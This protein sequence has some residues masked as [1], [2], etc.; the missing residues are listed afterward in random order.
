MTFIND[1]DLIIKKTKFNRS[2]VNGSNGNSTNDDV[3]Y[4]KINMTLFNKTVYS[5]DQDNLNIHRNRVED[6]DL[7]FDIDKINLIQ[8]SE[9]NKTAEIVDKEVLINNNLKYFLNNHLKSLNK[10]NDLKINSFIIK[11]LTNAIDNSLSKRMFNNYNT[12]KDNNNTDY[13]SSE[14]LVK[15]KKILN[16][17]NNRTHKLM[18]TN[19]TNYTLVKDLMNFNSSHEFS[20]ELKEYNTQN[21]HISNNAN[22]SNLINLNKFMFNKENLTISKNPLYMNKSNL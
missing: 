14:S 15:V 20:K 6:K 16:L 9:I 2:F 8:K 18:I 10:T 3:C 1:M 11:K 21:I 5:L 7:K 22:S 19:L 4:I 17:E 12:S 13:N